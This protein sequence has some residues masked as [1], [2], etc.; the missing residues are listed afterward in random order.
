MQFEL[1]IIKWLQ[2]FSNQ[3]WDFF[4][5]MWTI[6]GEELVIIAI[7]GFTYWCFDKKVG[8]ALG[9]TVFVSLVLNSLIKITFRR[10][11]PYVVD[12]QITNIRPQ[13]S[14][15]YSFPSGHTQ[16]AATVFGGLAVWLKKKWLTIS[17]IVIVVMVAISRMYLGVH[18]LTD[19]VV[20]GLLG[21]GLSWGFYKLLS[22]TDNRNKLYIWLLIGSGTLFVGAYLYYLLSV[23]T[24]V[25]DSDAFLLYNSLEGAAKMVGAITGF[26]LGVMFEHKKVVF[27]NHRNLVKNLI[28]LIV[29]IVVVMAFR[30]V[31]KAV[32]GFIVDPEALADGQMFKS[33]LAIIFDFLRYGGMVFVGIGLYPLVF[34]R[35]NI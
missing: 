20:G 4:F 5:Q 13:T 21:V 25:D 28:R 11:R 2:S 35:F 33:T 3:F 31:A 9:I 16:G 12:Q 19:V 8:E 6:F 7:L 30:I 27:D 14:G 22:K 10:L 1:E 34:K 18:F 32:F 24:T 26:V 17:V 29:G 15:G 23:E